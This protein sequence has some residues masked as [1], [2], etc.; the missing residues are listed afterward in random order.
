MFFKEQYQ[1]KIFQPEKSIF[2]NYSL[3]NMYIHSLKLDSELNPQ[4]TLS[5]DFCK[6]SSG[7]FFQNSFTLLSKLQLFMVF[8]KN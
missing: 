2:S 1:R 4:K 3:F 8:G 7:T 5:W 6:I